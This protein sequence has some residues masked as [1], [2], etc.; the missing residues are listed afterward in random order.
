VLLSHDEFLD[1]GKMARRVLMRTKS[2]LLGGQPRA[3]SSIWNGTKDTVGLQ[4]LLLAE[5]KEVPAPPS[6]K[7][8]L[9]AAELL[10]DACDSA[11]I[12]DEPDESGQPSKVLVA[13]SE[14]VYEVW[15]RWAEFWRRPIEQGRASKVEA[16][17]LAR[18][19]GFGAQTWRVRTFAHGRRK[20]FLVLDAESLNRLRRLVE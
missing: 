18:S 4:S 20:R 7:A 8:L 19:A 11:P 13:G 1:A 14:E 10:L 15:L 5:A 6:D 3:W 17:E 9:D 16:Q 12:A 2:I